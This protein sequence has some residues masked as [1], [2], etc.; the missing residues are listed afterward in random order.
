[1]TSR[2]EVLIAIDPGASGGLA[3]QCAGGEVVC[4]KMPAT[5]RD[6]LDLLLALRQRHRQ[7][8]AVVE[9]VGGYMPG[10]S[11]PAAAT[12]ARHMGHL[13]MALLAAQIPVELVT[14]A[15]WMRGIG[16]PAK[17]DKQARKNAIKAA[18]QR[19]YPATKVTLWNAD[20]LGIL[21]W[22]RGQDDGVKIK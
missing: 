3:V 15:K 1:M 11:G 5:P 17:L 9:N 18:M 22:S 6:L 14:P 4:V 8:R 20:A 21:T 12:F 13:D 7:I 16:I 10:N 19:R 2:S